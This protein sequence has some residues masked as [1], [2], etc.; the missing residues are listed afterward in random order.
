MERLLS[1]SV[2]GGELT[3]AGKAFFDHA[4]VTDRSAVARPMPALP[5]VLRA[6]LPLGFLGIAFLL[7]Y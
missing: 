4:R 3:G 5:P 2:H 1:R 7:Y 6:T